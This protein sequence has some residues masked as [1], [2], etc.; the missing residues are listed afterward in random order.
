MF[1][2]EQFPDH[3]Y[4]PNDVAVYYSVQG[5]N[6][7]TREWLEKANKIDPKD[8][9]VMRNLGYVCAKMGDNAAARKWYEAVIKAEPDGEYAARA[10]EALK[11]LK[12]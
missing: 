5:D 3:P 10:K 8:T 9:L 2:A 6:A 11:K 12:K 4:A 7:K 1:S